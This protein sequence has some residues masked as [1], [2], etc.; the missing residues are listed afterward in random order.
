MSWQLQKRFNACFVIPFNIM[1]SSCHIFW[2]R[3]PE[4]PRG[5]REIRIARMIF[6]K[7]SVG[8]RNAPLVRTSRMTQH[9]HKLSSFLTRKQFKWEAQ[10]GS[11]RLKS[12]G[13][14]V[15]YLNISQLILIFLTFKLLVIEIG[16]LQMHLF[17]QNT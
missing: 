1:I 2:I 17:N 8:K 4:L 12:V 9:F 6:E 3:C 10:N 16:Y 13:K 5:F 14:K 15:L 11:H 7:G